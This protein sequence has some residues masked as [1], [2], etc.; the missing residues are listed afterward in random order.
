M[1]TDDYPNEGTAGGAGLWVGHDQGGLGV[2][3]PSSPRCFPEV[4]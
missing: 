3:P 2:L 4:V 1:V